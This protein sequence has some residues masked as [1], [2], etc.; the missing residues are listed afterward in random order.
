MSLGNN[1]LLAISAAAVLAVSAAGTAALDQLGIASVVLPGSGSLRSGMSDGP[2]RSPVSMP[3]PTARLSFVSAAGAALHIPRSEELSSVSSELRPSIGDL[4][5]G[6]GLEGAA[7]TGAA[8]ET[9]AAWTV[10]A[11]PEPEPL[12]QGARAALKLPAAPEMTSRPRLLRPIVREGELAKRLAQISP[13]ASRRLAA[14]FA[15]AKVDWPPTEITLLTIKD[16]KAVELY[17]RAPGGTWKFVH[18]Y[19]VLAASG[20]MGPK[21]RQGDK[22]VPEGIYSIA[23]LNPASKYHVSLRVSYPNAF[24]RQMAQQDGR[25]ELGG[26][27]MF[28]GKALSA[29]CIAVGDEAA[30]ELFVLAAQTGLP[31]IKVIIAPTDF[32]RRPMP[33]LEEGQ[34]PWVSKLYTD[35]STAMA[36]YKPPQSGLLSFLFGK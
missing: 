16:E 11:T 22:Q 36:E 8:T 35:I 34:P 31:N 26:D 4:P 7:S 28:H 33:A 27:I 25:S 17:A 19:R 3:D 5:S 15:A 32:R 14:H 2:P 24:D 21:L 18:R 23:L 9:A 10:E 1:K 29:G 6:N 13:A 12:V 30:E 20:K